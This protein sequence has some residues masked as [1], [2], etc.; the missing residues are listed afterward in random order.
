MKRLFVVFACA[1]LLNSCG[2]APHSET[3]SA[4][5]GE[6]LSGGDTTVFINT[7]DSF[8]QFAANL[9][10]AQQENFKIGNAFFEQNWV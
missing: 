3:V 1:A 9:T 8:N 6:E 4:E 2:G 10:F 5:P 7:G